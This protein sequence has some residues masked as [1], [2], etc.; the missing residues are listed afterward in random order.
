MSTP[1]ETA[2]ALRPGTTNTPL[3]DRCRVN[4][5]AEI[6]TIEL[7][8]VGQIIYCVETDRYYKVTALKSRLIG[9]LTVPDAA[10]DT[11]EAIPVTTSEIEDIFLK[12]SW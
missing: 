7:P 10:V 8:F 4:T 5:L 11:Y 12:G 9:A 3:D 1:I 2:G 6:S